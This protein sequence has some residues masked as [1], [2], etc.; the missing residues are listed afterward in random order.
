MFRLILLKLLLISSLYALGFD[1]IEGES[2]GIIEQPNTFPEV[3]ATDPMLSQQND[4]PRYAKDKRIRNTRI[5]N[6]QTNTATGLLHG[7]KHA[8]PGGNLHLFDYPQNSP[9]AYQAMASLFD[10]T[11]EQPLATWQS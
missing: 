5:R 1:G 3:K 8:G 11:L 4:I 2:I 9:E 6:P 7:Y 10:N